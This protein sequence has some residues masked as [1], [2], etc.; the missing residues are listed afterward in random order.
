MFWVQDSDLTRMISRI[1]K[2]ITPQD[3]FFKV[4]FMI[5]YWYHLPGWHGFAFAVLLIGF[6]EGLQNKAPHRNRCARVAES[7]FPETKPSIYWIR[8]VGSHVGHLQCRLF[9]KKRW[10]YAQQI[11]F[12]H[13]HVR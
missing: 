5:W 12:R 2:E 9:A 13:L 8:I 6:K 1:V 4:F 3:C 10:N 7:N 11:P